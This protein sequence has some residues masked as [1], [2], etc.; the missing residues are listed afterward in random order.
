MT[1]SKT[2]LPLG[3]AYEIATPFGLP[4]SRVRNGGTVV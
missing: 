1:V 3:L 2:A 4:V